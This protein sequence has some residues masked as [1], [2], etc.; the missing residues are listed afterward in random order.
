[1]KGTIKFTEVVDASNDKKKSQ[2][3]EVNVTLEDH[4]DVDRLIN[5]LRD[6]KNFL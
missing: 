2:N 1:M 5:I 6:I 3:V 4:N